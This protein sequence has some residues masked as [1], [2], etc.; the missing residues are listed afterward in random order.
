[1]IH[2]LFIFYCARDP[3]KSEVNILEWYNIISLHNLLVLF[4]VP[5]VAVVGS[6]WIGCNLRLISRRIVVLGCQS[7]NAS[8]SCVIS[9][10]KWC[11][12]FSSARRSRRAHGIW[13]EGMR[14]WLCMA[15]DQDEPR[16][17]S[18]REMRWNV[19][20]S[21]PDGLRSHCLQGKDSP[22]PI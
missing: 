16:S 10:E 6:L 15:K 2:N 14:I 7:R 13:G 8:R 9:R 17:R 11:A 12:T 4:A 3:A 5:G 20:R 18:S 19:R 21:N 22:Q 1:M